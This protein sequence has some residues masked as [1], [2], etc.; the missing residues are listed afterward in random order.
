MNRFDWWEL[1]T[2]LDSRLETLLV[3]SIETNL[4]DEWK[5]VLLGS[6][7]IQRKEIEESLGE[8]VK[9]INSLFSVK[10]SK[11]QI[12]ILSVCYCAIP[13][14]TSHQVAR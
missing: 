4:F 3:E 7:K 13:A 6:P 14:L 11:T 10:L 9:Q 12:E 8:V 2:Q 1:R 5:C